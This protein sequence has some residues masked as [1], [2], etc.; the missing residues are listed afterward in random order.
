MLFIILQHYA[1][2][3]AGSILAMLLHNIQVAHKVSLQF[4]IFS[5]CKE[6]LSEY[7]K[8]KRFRQL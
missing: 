8:R 2:I 5:N 7:L 1:T 6:T 4:E 3:V